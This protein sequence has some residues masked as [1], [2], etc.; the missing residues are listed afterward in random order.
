[1]LGRGSHLG[2]NRAQINVP[3]PLAHIVGVADSISELRTLAANI[4]NSCHNSRFPSRPVAENMLP[5]DDFTGISGIP[6]TA[7]RSS[8]A[9]GVLARPSQEQWDRNS[10]T[11]GDARCSTNN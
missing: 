6:P 3:A 9:T 11:G 10:G 1:M 2:M 8:E 7:S 5:K 4:T